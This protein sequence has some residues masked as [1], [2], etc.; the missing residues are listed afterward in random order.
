MKAKNVLGLL[1]VM[2]AIVLITPIMCG[3]TNAA[4]KKMSPVRV[5][6][7]G[8]PTTLN[9]LNPGSYD[10]PTM[11]IFYFFYEPLYCYGPDPE[12]QMRPW[13]A[14][15]DPIFETLGDKTI[16]TIHLRK[17][18]RWWDG[19]QFTADDVVFHTEL[20]MKCR[21]PLHWFA[22]EYMGKPFVEG[23]EKVDDYTVKYTLTE[24][25]LVPFYRL[26][27]QNIIP[28]HQWEPV[29]EKAKTACGEENWEEINTY[30]QKHE[31]EVNEWIGLGPF[32]PVKWE[33][34]SYFLLEANKDYF[35][36]GEMIDLGGGEKREI[37]PFVD[38]IIAYFYGN[39]DTGTLAL[40]RGD[41]DYLYQALPTAKLP[42][43]RE[44]PKNIVVETFDYIGFYAINFNQRTLEDELKWPM[45]DKSFRVAIAYLIDRE[46]LIERIVQ[47][48]GEPIYG[49]VPYGMKFWYNPDTTK[50]GEGLSNVEREYHAYRALKDAGYSWSV[51]PQ[52]KL[53]DGK[54]VGLTKKG[55]NLILPDGTSCSTVRLG[56]GLT[57][58][59]PTAAEIATYVVGRMKDIGIPAEGRPM[60]SWTS[61]NAQMKGDW[62]V[63][64]ML[65][66]FGAPD[67][68]EVMMLHSMQRPKIMGWL[69]YNS[70]AWINEEYDTLV[71][72]FEREENPERRREICFQCQKMVAEDLPWLMLWSPKRIEAYR[73]DR[74]EGWYC[75]PL[76][77]MHN[78]VG[79]WNWLVLKPKS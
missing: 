17:D 79:H 66:R 45:C 18:V 35:A 2:V 12:V 62:E 38:R 73:I 23:I 31:F 60:D 51:D 16:V 71:D 7:I 8:E 58:E 29:L 36:G 53:E 46:F 10:L 72:E 13:L 61:L 64:I 56:H 52:F 39:I 50:Y 21:F 47:G 14:E 59:D 28:K 69:A 34:G 25:I 4:K 33:R 77:G 32:K 5:G 70:G 43:M 26:I 76:Y 20:V 19:V 40:R 30:L 65:S 75:Q 11:F 54:A 57:T 74:F 44:D 37:G 48:F 49:I 41:I 22:Y 24:P 78:D 42:L 1:C 68:V 15:G 63:S 55:Q 6:I 3:C 67:M 27:Q 9:P